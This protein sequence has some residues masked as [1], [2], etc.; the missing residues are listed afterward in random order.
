MH[1]SVTYKTAID[2]LRNLDVANGSTSFKIKERSFF[3]HDHVVKN[4]ATVHDSGHVRL[5]PKSAWKRYNVELR[6][7]DTEGLFNIISSPLLTTSKVGLIFTTRVE[8]GM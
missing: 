4:D 6:L 5:L 2:I 7:K 1:C 3:F 8:N